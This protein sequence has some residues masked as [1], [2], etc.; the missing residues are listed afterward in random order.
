MVGGAGTV[1][2]AGTAGQSRAAGLGETA[3]VETLE[4]LDEDSMV[5][6]LLHAFL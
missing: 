1:G 2:T 3:K 6:G 4:V 5:M